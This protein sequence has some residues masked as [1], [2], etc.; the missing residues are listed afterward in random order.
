MSP[1]TQSAIGAVLKA[2]DILRKG[3]GSISQKTIKAGNQNF[4]TQYDYAAE[5]A[6]IGTLRQSY[7][8]HAFLAEES[9]ASSLS[10]A[11]VIWIIDPLD[12]TLN[13]AH[14]I[15]VFCISVAALGAEGLLCGVIY[16][17][18]SQELFVAEKGKGAFLNDKKIQVSK[19]VRLADCLGATGFPRDIQQ[20]PQNCVVDFIKILEQGTVVRNMGSSALNIAYVSAGCFDAYWAVSLHSWDIAAGVLLIQEAGGKTSTYQGG[21]YEVLSSAP[22]IVSNG[23]VHDELLKYLFK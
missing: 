13:F 11:E 12:G 23:L 6:I 21:P 10:N 4:A 15:P 3:F 14:H 2:G 5:E 16:Q 17:P 19:T 22:L 1:L 7:P 18:M 9:G 20:N 8:S